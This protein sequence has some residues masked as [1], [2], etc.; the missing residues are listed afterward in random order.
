MEP[1]ED[2][3]SLAAL[4]TDFSRELSDLLR[5]EVALARAEAA[6]KVTQV[7]NAIISLGAGGVA[8]LVGLYFLFQALAL[9]LAALLA[10]WLGAQVGIW[11]APLLVG[12]L[13]GLIGWAVLRKGLTSLATTELT[14]R[15]TAETLRRDADLV[16][17]HTR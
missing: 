9:G 5:K 12:L 7:K 14:P 11:L 16:K 4:F 15:R 10:D 1:A 2:S 17:E 3:R 13:A 8:L 6:E